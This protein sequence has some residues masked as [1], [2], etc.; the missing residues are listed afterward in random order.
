MS[1]Q[2]ADTSCPSHF[3][4]LGAEFKRHG[5]DSALPEEQATEFE[6][7]DNFTQFLRGVATE[8]DTRL[9]ERISGPP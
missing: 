4:R 5:F 7:Y 1:D 6:K 9:R 2:Q 8:A 3:L